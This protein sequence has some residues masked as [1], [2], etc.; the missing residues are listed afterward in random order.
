MTMEKG[1]AQVID[2]LCAAGYKA[3]VVGGCVRDSLLGKMPQDWDVCTSALPEQVISL[4]G[5]AHTLL[6]GIKHG[7]VT[8]RMDNSF[9][10]VTTFRTEGAY[11][12]GRH[13]DRVDFIGDVHGDLS[14]RDFTMNA[15]AYHPKE[16]L[17]DPFG[18]RKDLLQARVV[19]AVGDPMKRF[20]EDA[21]RILRLF[22]FAAREELSI[23]EATLEAALALADGLV[24][25]SGE[26]IREELMKLLGTKNPG[27]YMPQKVISACIPALGGME[28]QQYRHML[29]QV[30][31]A[32]A[33]AALRL[34]LLVQ[35][36]TNSSEA[37]SALK[38]DHETLSEVSGLVQSLN[39]APQPHIRAQARRM[40]GSI[41]LRQIE[42]ITVLRT[43]Q[44]AC[45]SN[46]EDLL[47]LLA[48]ARKAQ[49]EGDCC[50][51][52]DLAV[53]GRDVIALGVSPGPKVGRM[54][55]DM[56]EAV[57]VD[58]VENT[59]EALFPW[60]AEWIKRN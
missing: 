3:Y 41:G 8:V 38:L 53:S 16:G 7:T 51:L 42:R 28:K 43:A 13:P 60:M 35:E 18:G 17:I 26:R 44:R 50:R 56:L 54:L 37:L 32:P 30:N 10:E 47:V 31:A 46:K 12:D 48:A 9:Y 29:A 36:E 6:T 34:A 14:R 1:A 21:L 52:R 4:F 58:E 19:R 59:R 57:I 24:R 2:K 15:M 5:Q 22:R 33:D 40:L 27:D 23:D 11:S 45:G 55:E 25:V 49:E 20:E 39:L